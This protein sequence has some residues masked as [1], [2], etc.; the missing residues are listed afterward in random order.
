MFSIK[1]ELERLTPIGT[2]DRPD[3]VLP[4]SALEQWDSVTTALARSGKQQLRANQNMD[5]ALQ[6]GASALAEAEA[7][8]RLMDEQAENGRRQIQ[9][10]QE[11]AREVRLVVLGTIDMLDDL[12]AMARQKGDP[13]WVG[14]VERL[15]TRTLDV[16]AQMGLSE[17]PAADR[18]FDEQAH[19]AVDAVDRGERDAFVVVE[20]IRR[21]FR[22]DGNVLRR[23]QV[24]AT[25]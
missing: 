7:R 16:L 20:V 8:G 22:W 1:Q 13:Q 10:L 9:R 4:P 12:M 17:I 15:V 24:V 3:D 21:G 18:P 6:Q 14:R 5:L 19:E 23:S 25:R 11:D 2:D